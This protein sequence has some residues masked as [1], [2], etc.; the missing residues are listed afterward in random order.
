VTLQG[1]VRCASLV[2]AHPA[3]VPKFTQAAEQEHALL[4][5]P[6]TSLHVGSRHGACELFSS[7]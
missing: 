6:Q 7:V 3:T 4:S 1:A 2:Q 5:R